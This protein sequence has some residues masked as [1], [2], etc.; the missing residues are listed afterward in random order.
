MKDTLKSENCSETRSYLGTQN[1]VKSTFE[2]TCYCSER[3]SW[4]LR[5]NI[6]GDS[7]QK[8]ILCEMGNAVCTAHR[9]NASI[10]YCRSSGWIGE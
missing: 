7:R 2:E 5:W 4:S 1:D 8:D 3:A 9:G 10:D 6:R